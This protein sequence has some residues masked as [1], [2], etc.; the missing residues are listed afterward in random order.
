M[1]DRLSGLRQ[2]VHETAIPFQR[3]RAAYAE[4]INSEQISEKAKQIA[5]ICISA[6]MQYGAALMDLR[7]YL[8]VETFYDIDNDEVGRVQNSIHSLESENQAYER[9]LIS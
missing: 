6:G 3:A 8:F 7:D 1:D 2:A 4:A 9:V 5:R